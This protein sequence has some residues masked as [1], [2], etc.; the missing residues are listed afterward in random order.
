M[1][2][3]QLES[4][5]EVLAALADPVRRRVY[6]HVR[7]RGEVSRDQAA[8][9]LRI[10]RALAAFHLDKLVAQGLLDVSYRRLTA[11]TG[12]G[13]GRPS[14][15]YRRSG[16]E[17][18]VALPE[19]RYDVLARV[20]AQGV[21]A[22]EDAPAAGVRRAAREF[23]GALGTAARAR[24]GERATPDALLGA[25][26]AVLREYGFEPAQDDD[27]LCL[28]N[29]PFDAVA[30]EHRTLVCGANLA[31]MQGLVAGLGT[32]GLTPE[33]APQ[34]GRCCVV[35]RADDGAPALPEPLTP[36][37]PRL[38]LVPR[39][40]SPQPGTRSPSKPSR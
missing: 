5:L 11:R 1:A 39:T 25:T 13:A 9:A 37:G 32:V 17:L 35:W 15:L 12:R 38:A 14:K 3:G 20:L 24:L 33:L 6:L 4:D 31:L 28:R 7:E 16:R 18:S 29:C 8:R 10:S 2:V 34:P 19:R 23:G 27:G 22:H 21:V 30:Q 26:R 36:D 40:T